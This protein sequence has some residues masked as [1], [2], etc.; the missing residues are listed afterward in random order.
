MAVVSHDL[1]NY[2]S[3]ISMSAQMLSRIIPAG[4]GRTGRKQV[5]AIGRAA[6]RM[7]Q[8]IEGLRDATMIE[9]GHFA[10]EARTEDVTALVD[11]AVK[12]LE[13]QTQGR[14]LQLKV[15]LEDSPSPVH[16]DRER[17]LQ[18]ITNLV[19]NAI[20]F[21]KDGGAIRIAEKT[22]G[23]V[24]CFSVSD[25]GSGIPDLAVPHVFDR[26][27]KGGD[28]NRKGTGLGLFIAKGIVEAHRGRIWVESTVGLGSTFYFTLPVASAGAGKSPPLMAG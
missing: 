24:V 22:D 5:E 7:N 16:C 4:E 21:T 14:S 27:W 9:S 13:P 1:R 2:L 23:A 26:Y 8:L 20:K 6:T 11:E 25:T 15:Q 19:G 28:G 18:V 17:V 10:I 3:S 12:L